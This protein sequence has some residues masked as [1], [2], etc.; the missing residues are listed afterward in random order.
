[1]RQSINVMF[2]PEEDGLI[3]F[4]PSNDLPP[5]YYTAIQTWALCFLTTPGTRLLDPNYGTS[6]L[7]L[8]N[9]GRLFTKDDVYSAF[10]D[11]T[12]RCYPY[13]QPDSPGDVYVVE[14]WISALDVVNLGDDLRLVMYIAFQF[15]D[16]TKTRINLELQ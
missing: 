6:F 11:A 9:S 3:P 1:M 8:L 13:C 7:T 10:A 15:S 5:K 14:A 2:F 12:A 4:R 16:G